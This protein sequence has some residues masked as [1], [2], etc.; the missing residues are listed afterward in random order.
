MQ[1]VPVS[2]KSYKYLVLPGN[3]SSLV[4]EALERRC[5]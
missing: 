4:T 3:E 5:W 2:K 1:E